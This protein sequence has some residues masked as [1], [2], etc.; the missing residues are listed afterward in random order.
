MRDQA[1]AIMAGQN[2]EFFRQQ[3]VYID[4][5]AISRSQAFV[6]YHCQMT[7]REESGAYMC[8]RRHPRRHQSTL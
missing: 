1:S 3:T 4:I 6:L 8:G 7:G 5:T 2:V